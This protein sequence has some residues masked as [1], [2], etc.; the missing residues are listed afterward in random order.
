MQGIKETSLAG[1]KILLLYAR[2]FGYDKIVK[3]KLESLGAVVDLYDARANI[4]T[5]E[6]AIKK[7]DS[8]YYYKKQ[9][10][11]HHNIQQE[12]KG[13]KYDFIFSN[14]NIEEVTLKNYRKVF[15][16]ATMV[17]YLDDSV[18][19]MIGV[20]K[21]FHC[22]DRVLTFDKADS[23]KYDVN[24]RPLFFGDSFKQ[25]KEKNLSKK[26]DICFVGTCHSDRLAII[27]K[28]MKDYPNYRYFFHCYLQSWFMYYYY[29]FKDVEYRKKSKRFF[30]Y[31]QISMNQVA[32]AMAYSDSILDIQH[33]KQ[34]GL[35]M[36]TIE[37]LGLGK[38]IITTNSDIRNYDFYNE[39]N[40][41]VVDREKPIIPESFIKDIYKPLSVELYH[42]YSI[43]GWIE[44]VFRK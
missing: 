26:Y 39:H 14:E 23:E 36:R 34:T 28:I 43:A 27:S 15:P 18:A 10:K 7:V 2:F 5:V 42:K 33:P 44:D 24:F 41:L 25:L 38:K 11:F 1:K 21:N 13:K 22:Y 8:R 17:L 32:Q 31:D 4:S 9:R 20:D 29:A 3:E 6:K 12:N 40:V 19:N 30:K 37:T 16:E 35:T